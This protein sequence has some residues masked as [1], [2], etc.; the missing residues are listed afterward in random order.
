M[1]KG[2][3]DIAIR[4]LKAGD[5]RREIPDRGCA[6]LYAIVQ[7]SGR[8]SF[9]V[10]Y[11]YNGTPRKLTLAGGLTLAAARKLCSDALLDLEKGHD[12]SESKKTAKQKAATAKAETVQWV[13]EQWLKREG[14]KLRTGEERKQT[15]QRLVY[16]EIGSVPLA[17]LKRSDIV[18]LLDKV[19]DERGDCTAN[20]AL[21]YLRKTF[22]W[23]ASRV[24]DF[25]SPIVRGMSRY[26]AQANRGTRTLTDDEI[27]TLWQATEPNDKAPQ[28]FPALV[29]FLLLTAARRTEANEMTW[30]EVNGSDW[31]LPAARNKVKI[32]LVR[33]LSK[34]ALAVL[35]SVPVVDGSKFVFGNGGKSPL[36]LTRPHRRLMEESGVANWKPH[37]LRRTSRT[38][39][40]RA[41]VNSDVAERC[42][43]HVIGG[44]RGT[45]DKHKYH[46]EMQQV[47]EALAAQID[48]I[49]N[50][51]TNVVTPL[52]RGQR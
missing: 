27:R 32:D 33:P 23:H 18:K 50:P 12:P 6:G 20:L 9:A 15:L 26:D 2:F 25:N 31:T 17:R 52:R 1:A 40:S 24:D 38:L 37:D 16:P 4:N 46:A 41:G 42:L 28:P 48:R 49:V 8:K 10:R 39:L 34:A 7:P 29:R 36:S 35:E 14:G 11:R 45:Y 22:N 13:C 5:T 43:G 19:Q 51:L 30:A 47:F 3:T 44:V 21:A